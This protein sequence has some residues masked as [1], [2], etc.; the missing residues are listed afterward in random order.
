MQLPKKIT[1][2]SIVNAVVE[3]KYESRIPFELLMGLLVD[4]FDDSYNY[5]T[6]PLRPLLGKQQELA[7]NF[8]SQALLYNERISLTLLPNALGFNCLGKYIGWTLFK[9]EINKALQIIYSTGHIVKWSRVGLRYITEYLKTDLKD[10]T[11]FNFTF[12]FPEVQ[13]LSTTF[14]NEF[15]FKGAKVIMNL[16]NKI[17]TIRQQEMNSTVEIIPSS[18]IDIDVIKEPLAL[19][20]VNQIMN[21]IEEVH[22]HEKEVFFTLLTDDFL[23]TLNPEY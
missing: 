2:D 12:G 11:K 23:K 3:V 16:N 1:P 13:S 20:Q 19:A 6:R 10:C 9:E 18:T 14:H 4:K 7:I 8:G 22:E 5:T 21:I 15:E 17:P